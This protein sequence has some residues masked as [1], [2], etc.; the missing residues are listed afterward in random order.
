MI[1][2]SFVSPAAKPVLVARTMGVGALLFAVLLAPAVWGQTSESPSAELPT[3][4]SPAAETPAPAVAPSVNLLE[5]LSRGGWLMTPIGVLSVLVVVVAVERAIALR[6]RRLIPPL[7]VSGLGDLGR[8]VEDF[9][10]EAAYRLCQQHPSAAA[11]VVKTLLL[12]IGRPV[13][14]VQAAV[15]QA[16]EREA[17]RLL[18]PVR[19]LSLSAA[20]A[21]LLG[22]LG[23]VW[24][25]IESFFATANLPAG[26][27]RADFLA[28]GIY[29]ALVT[30]FAGLCVAIPSA[31]LAH[32]FEARVEF[33]MLRIEELATALT[34]HTE[35]YEGKLRVQR[36]G[37]RKPSPPAAQAS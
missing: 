36:E 9:D 30:T 2:L 3:D 4:A 35:R 33:V 25:M 21:P 7:L 18:G 14:E 1:R 8:D 11:S 13:S 27:S 16:C 10:P 19:L 20:V 31:I 6:R 32:L 5:L 24:G 12:K 29:T 22:L 34:P 37:R 15:D 26:V 28:G 23:T 17:A